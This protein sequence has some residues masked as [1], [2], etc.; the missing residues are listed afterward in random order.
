MFILFACLIFAVLGSTTFREISDER[1]LRENTLLR[2]ANKNLEAQIAEDSIR[3][4]GAWTGQIQTPGAT[5]NSLY[6]FR[7]NMPVRIDANGGNPF[8][9]PADHYVRLDVRSPI[10]SFS[11][12]PYSWNWQVREDAASYDVDCIDPERDTNDTM[13]IHYI[14]GK[15]DR[16]LDLTSNDLWLMSTDKRGDLH[17]VIWWELK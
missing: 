6:G 10:N 16:T 15:A 4:T 9:V 14:E 5:V 12:A 17:V 8:V 3:L 1:T 11:A 13:K 7:N 2:M